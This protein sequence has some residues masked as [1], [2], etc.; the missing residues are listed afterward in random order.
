M[1][2]KKVNQELIPYLGMAFEKMQISDYRIACKNGI[3]TVEASV[4]ERTFKRIKRLA[5]VYKLTY[6][7]G[8]RH[9]CREQLDEPVSGVIPSEERFWFN[10]NTL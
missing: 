2:T 4:S 1:E 6:E 5:W 10:R 8:I 9:I 7:T 3:K